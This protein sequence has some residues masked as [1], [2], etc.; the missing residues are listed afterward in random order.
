ML[1]S[2]AVAVIGHLTPG[3]ELASRREVG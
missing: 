1:V 2:D 3:P